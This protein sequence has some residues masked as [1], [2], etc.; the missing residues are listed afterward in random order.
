M[1]HGGLLAVSPADI[2]IAPVQDLSLGAVAPREELRQ[3]FQQGL[4]S[5]RY[6]PLALDYVDAKLVDA[7]FV[8]GSLR[9]EAVLEIQVLA[10]D[11]S[12]WDLHSAVSVEVR[13]RLVNS[14]AAEGE[15]LWGANFTK[16]LNLSSERHTSPTQALVMG[17][18]A[19]MVAAELLAVLP[20]RNP[21]PGGN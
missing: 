2:V 10:W 5:R 9:E 6:S 14:A 20:A 8:A 19:Q 15:P 16:R 1:N 12:L 17:R 18:A 11:M 13:A 21:V 7:A 4:V 3:A